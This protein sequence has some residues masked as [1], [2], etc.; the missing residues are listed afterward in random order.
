MELVHPKNL[1]RFLRRRVLPTTRPPLAPRLRWL[2]GPTTCP[3]LP[4]GSPPLTGP[5]PP[6]GPDAVAR[7]MGAYIR[8]VNASKSGSLTTDLG[9]ASGGVVEVSRDF[10]RCLAD[11]RCVAARARSLATSSPRPTSAA[12]V[13]S[14]SASIATMLAK[15]TS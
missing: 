8:L 12:S 10:D 2:V 3:P 7:A 13:A 5:P 14:A 1:R 6:T 9:K 4:P 11:A 15:P